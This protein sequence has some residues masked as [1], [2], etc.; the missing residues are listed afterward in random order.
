LRQENPSRFAARQAAV[1]SL[2]LWFG[3]GFAGRMIGFT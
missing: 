3:V 1:V 2:V